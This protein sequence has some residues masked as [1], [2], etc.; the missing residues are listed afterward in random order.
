MCKLPFLCLAVLSS[1]VALAHGSDVPRDRPQRLL[2]QFKPDQ[3]YYV[4]STNADRWVLTL[5]DARGRE[6]LKELRTEEATIEA[7][8]FTISD[9]GQDWIELRSA[10]KPNQRTV[11][12]LSSIG[13]VIRYVD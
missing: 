1:V 9:I 11:L 10:R 2:D 13:R 4:S 6:S 3:T 8:T 12:P 5:L 7:R